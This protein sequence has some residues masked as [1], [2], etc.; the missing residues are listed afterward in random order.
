MNM[1]CKIVFI[2]LIAFVSIS[3]PGCY[4]TQI[5]K[6]EN[7]FINTEKDIVVHLADGREIEFEKGNYSIAKT[8]SISTLN[9]NGIVNSMVRT[10]EPEIFNGEINFADIKSITTKTYPMVSNSLLA[11]V[12]SPISAIV[13]ITLL[14]VTLK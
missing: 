8:D 6:P 4:R 7:N 14:L 13:V 11:I 2:F 12:F 9:G 5:F 1:P 10:D 3:I